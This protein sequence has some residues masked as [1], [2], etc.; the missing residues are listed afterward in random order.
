[1]DATMRKTRTPTGLEREPATAPGG[2]PTYRPRLPWA[3][4]QRNRRYTLYMLRELS[5]V[6]VALWSALFLVQLSRLRRG[7]DSYERFVAAQHSPGWMAFHLITLLFALLHAVTWFQLTGVV[8][9]GMAQKVRIGGRRLS[10]QQISAG[11]FAGW[12][13]ASLGILLALL[14]GGRKGQD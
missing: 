1:M 7:K 4:W 8:M 2:Y 10:A 12:A 13:A 5:S 6:F 14:L 3:W 9:S 11:S